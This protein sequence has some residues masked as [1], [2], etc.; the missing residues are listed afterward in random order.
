MTAATRGSRPFDFAQGWRWYR[1][2]LAL[3]LLTTGCAANHSA[4]GL[5]LATDP[6]ARQV[7]ISHEAIPGFMDA[8]VMPFA[9]SDVK[10]IEGVIPGDR[11]AFRLRVG[12]D[13]SSIDRIQV[14]SAAREDEGLTS[15]PAVPALTPI[16]RTL[17]DVPL[18]DQD[19]RQATL[20]NWRG[21]VVAINFIYTR[22]PLPDYCPRLVSTFDAL[23]RR[24]ADRLDRDLMLVTVTFDP[25]YDTPPV[26]KRFALRHDADVPGWRFLTGS[27][28]DIARF[29]RAVGVQYWAEE[30]L[31]THSLQT[32]VVDREGRLQAV[33]EGK[34]FTTTQLGDLVEDVLQR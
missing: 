1:T 24:F 13:R 27:V 22:C 14:L 26:L 30:G 33:V 4:R 21:R 31:I 28:A 29:C 18:R 34:E 3:T 25:R 2:L 8:M 32:A 7:T 17:P 10:E 5:V 11:I 6:A 19:D 20:S 16:G 23:K 9:I 12:K 15:T